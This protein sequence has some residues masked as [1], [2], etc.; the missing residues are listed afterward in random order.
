MRQASGCDCRLQPPSGQDEAVSING[1]QRLAGQDRGRG[2]GHDQGFEGDAAEYVGG[3]NR[4]AL[5]FA[6]LYL[7]LGE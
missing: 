5:G 3:R 2:G 4:P 1:T 7:P 6:V